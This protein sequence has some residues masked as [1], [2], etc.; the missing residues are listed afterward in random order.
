MNIELNKPF[1]F[2][3]NRL[4]IRKD[5]NKENIY[6]IYK[7]SKYYPDEI[8]FINE[9]QNGKSEI[10]CTYSDFK[11]LITNLNKHILVN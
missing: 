4:E 10:R 2:Q 6:R 7:I 3:G 5:V 8:G 1:S 9:N 11:E